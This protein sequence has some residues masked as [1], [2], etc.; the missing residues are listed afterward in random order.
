LLDGLAMRRFL[1]VLVL[2]TPACVGDVL[3]D[4]ID[5]DGGDPSISVDRDE[6]TAEGGDEG[7]GASIS[8]AVMCADGPTVKG[9]DVSKFQPTINWN[10]VAASGVEFVFI[11]AAYGTTVDPKFASHWQG[12][13]DAGL[14][15]GAYQYVRLSQNVDAQVDVMLATVGELEQ[16]DLPMVLDVEIGFNEGFS[17][18]QWRAFIARWVQRVEEATGKRPIIYTGGPFWTTYVADSSYGDYP[19]WEPRYSTTCPNVPTGWDRWHFWQYTDKGTTPGISGPTDRNLFNGD[20]DALLAFAQGGGMSPPDPPPPTTEWLQVC[21]ASWLNH[22]SGPGT[23]F[24]I[25]RALPGGAQ[26]KKLATSGD[27]VQCE[28]QGLSGWSKNTYLCPSTGP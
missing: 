18:A 8:E 5:D 7:A 25:L 21:N 22:R 17:K 20:R 2:V 24:S 16:D 15:R 9:L 12:A 14:L 10:Q 28:Y 19:L 13:R 1:S 3:D 11:R 27:W 23:T 26:V 4:G 6:G